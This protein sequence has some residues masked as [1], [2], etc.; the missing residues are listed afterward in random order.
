[1]AINLSDSQKTL[2]SAKPT[3]L[4][5]VGEYFKQL[6]TNIE[7]QKLDVSNVKTI[8]GQSIVGT[9]N[10]S[11]SDLNINLSDIAG[12]IDMTSVNSSILP[13]TDGIYNIGSI[14]SSWNNVYTQN[15]Y[16]GASKVA[17]ESYV[18]DRLT[19]LVNGAPVALDTLKEIADQLASDES[20]AS[21]LVT[22]VSGKQAT[23]TTIGLLKGTGS[24]LIAQAIADTDYVTPSGSI[25]GNAATATK[26]ASAVNIGGVSFDGSSAINL[27]GVN[28]AG[29]QNTSGSSASC[30]GNSATATK[31][32]TTRTINGANFDGSANIVV[33]ANTNNTQTIKFDTGTTEGTDKYTFDGS[34]AKTIDIKAGTN[35]SITKALGSIT[36]NANDTSVAWTEVT[37]KPDF[38]ENSQTIAYNYT[39]PAGRNA[40]IS[41]PITVSTGYAI[42]VSAGSRLVVL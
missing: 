1:M 11:L 25:T 5:Q 29:N 34:I 32:Q 14:T 33:T 36:I 21:A 18:T 8:G 37:G 28:T 41:G 15:V 10:I 31:L 6:S 38:Y 26:L 24:G 39:V 13:D 30:T 4:G 2:V 27:P 23:I 20:A 19:N 9:G 40:T 42:S 22:T 3:I 12:S 7:S 16:M 35:V 17:T